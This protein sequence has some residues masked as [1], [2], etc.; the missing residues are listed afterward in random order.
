MSQ[1]LG[2]ETRAI[3]DAIHNTEN[4]AE[5]YQS[6]FWMMERIGK[7]NIYKVYI[8]EDPH[9]IVMTG[10]DV[11]TQL[12]I[13]FPH[14][15]SRIHF[16]HTDAAYAV[17]VN[18]LRVTLRR[19]IATMLPLQFVDD[20]FCEYDITAVMMIETFG[21]GF[22]YEAGVYNVILNTGATDLIF[23]LFYIEKLET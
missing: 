12:Q 18:H 21:R 7:T 14:R 15:W 5:R 17:S 20:L 23:P 4:S 16:Y 22:E 3:I 19:E 10:A 2:P 11:V 8:N 1:R 6:G 13:P 9:A